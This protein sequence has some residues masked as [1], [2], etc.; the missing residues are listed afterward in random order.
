MVALLIWFELGRCSKV[1]SKV[2]TKRREKE[3]R[4]ERELERDERRLSKDSEF[5]F[6]IR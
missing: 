5:S 2:R 4:K 3:R 6:D 1:R